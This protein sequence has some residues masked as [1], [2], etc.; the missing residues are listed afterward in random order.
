MKNYQFLSKIATITIIIATTISSIQS[1][2]QQSNLIQFN[3]ENWQIFRGEV[4]E[5]L[6]RQSFKGSA[7][8]KD[9]EFV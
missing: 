6:G 4:T 3:E 1:Q 7:M 9:Y 2:S 8:L 5:Y